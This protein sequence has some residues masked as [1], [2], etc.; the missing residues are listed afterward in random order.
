M[1]Y[2]PFLHEHGTVSVRS[3]HRIAPLIIVLRQSKDYNMMR[4]L[5]AYRPVMVQW[6]RGSGLL[7]VGGGDATAK[8]HMAGGIRTG[9]LSV[10]G[11]SRKTFIH[12]ARKKCVKAQSLRG[13]LPT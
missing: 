7:G 8:L 3:S 5:Q 10:T 11:A 13:L 12:R 9:S 1:T 4:H 2:I 6:P